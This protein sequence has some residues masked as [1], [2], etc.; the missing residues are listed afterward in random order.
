V[1]PAGSVA[2]ASRRLAI[3]LLLGLALGLAVF[4]GFNRGLGL[5][6]P[7]GFLAGVI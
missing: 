1:S 7:A 3:D 2:A 6:L 5:S 4:I